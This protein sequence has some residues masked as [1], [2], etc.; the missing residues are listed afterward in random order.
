MQVDW[1]GL[2][3]MGRKRKDAAFVGYRLTRGEKVS[4]NGCVK[5]MVSLTRK[6]F[7]EEVKAPGGGMSLGTS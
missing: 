4:L 2:S 1:M 7:H 5:E 6:S 3:E